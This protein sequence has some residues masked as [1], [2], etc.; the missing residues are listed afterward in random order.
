MGKTVPS[1]RIALEMEI[2]R[3]KGFRKALN[4]EEDREVFETL[5][6]MCRNNAT[7]SGNAC[8]PIIFE[9][10]TMSII[11]SQEK[12]MLELG[13]KLQE[14]LWQRIKAQTDPNLSEQARSSNS[15][16]PNKL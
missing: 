9:P 12:K 2:Q 5:M 4:S 14:L 10:M 15:D 8:N 7:A 16:K 13:Y 1:Y 6:D 3:W 11:L